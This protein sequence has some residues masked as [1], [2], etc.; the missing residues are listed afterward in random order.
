MLVNERVTKNVPHMPKKD[1]PFEA[2][3]L[4]QT[5]IFVKKYNLQLKIWSR[6]LKNAMFLHFFSVSVAVHT[7]SDE[8]FHLSEGPMLE[9]KKTMGEL[10]PI[11]DRNTGS[12]DARAFLKIPASPAVRGFFFFF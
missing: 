1:K 6:T 7:K 12:N 2:T 11:L 10:V 4:F 8:H 5:T 9:N 3:E